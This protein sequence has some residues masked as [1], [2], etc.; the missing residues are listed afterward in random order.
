[1]GEWRQAAKTPQTLDQL[2]VGA[3]V[4]GGEHI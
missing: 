1:M 2:L 3:V 4:L